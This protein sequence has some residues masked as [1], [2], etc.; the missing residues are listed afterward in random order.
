MYGIETATL[1]KRKSL[2][3]GYS[4]AYC[5]TLEIGTFSKRINAKRLYVVWDND[6]GQTAT[7]KERLISNTGYVIRDN[8]TCE[9]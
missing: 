4:G 1:V 2:Y 7:F 5:H 8:N 6:V 3:A 9:T